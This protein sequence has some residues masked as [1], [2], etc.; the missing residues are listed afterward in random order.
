MEIQH[1]VPRRSIA[2]QTFSASA[3]S[4][5]AWLIKTRGGPRSSL[6]I[7]G[8]CSFTAPPPQ[9][10]AKSKVLGGPREA[11]RGS[12]AR[13]LLRFHGSTDRL[14]NT[15]GFSKS[16]ANLNVTADRNG[17]I[18]G[19]KVTDPRKVCC[20]PVRVVG[21]DQSAGTQAWLQKR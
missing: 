11:N 21:H 13:R 18:A 8:P 14:R 10:K 16:A 1:W 5:V 19:G 2:L 12:C 6:P 15:R 3:R 17:H 20:A 4:A 7:A 9:V